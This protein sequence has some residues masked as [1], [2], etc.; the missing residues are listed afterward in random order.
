MLDL[1][2]IWTIIFKLFDN[3]VIGRTKNILNYKYKN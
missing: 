3:G 2:I 1:N